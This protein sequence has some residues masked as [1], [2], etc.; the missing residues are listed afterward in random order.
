M[1]IV[2]ALD[3]PKLLGAAIKDGST[4][5]AWRAMLKAHFALPRSCCIG[6]AR[7]A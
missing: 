1:N 3:D 4:F 2:A 6:P 5:T 7:A